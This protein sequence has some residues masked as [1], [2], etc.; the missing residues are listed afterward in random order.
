MVNIFLNCTQI[1]IPF[2]SE[3]F[4]FLV[5]LLRSLVTDEMSLR[6]NATREGVSEII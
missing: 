6:G 4:V 2:S 3:L 5:L 1:V